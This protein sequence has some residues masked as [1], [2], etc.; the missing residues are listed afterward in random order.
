MTTTIYK[1][2]LAVRD[3][4]TLKLPSFSKVLA[5]AEQEGKLMLWAAVSADPAPEM[6]MVVVRIAGTGNP[7][8]DE[9]I[10]MGHVGTVVMSNGF[11]WHVFVQDD[12]RSK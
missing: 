9:Y 4:Q 3:Y 5:V 8:G 6:R 2:P 10:G 7:M 11:V 1:Y 12:F